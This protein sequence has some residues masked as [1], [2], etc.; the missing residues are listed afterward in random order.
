MIRRLI[1]LQVSKLRQRG[2][3]VG[4][5]S[6]AIIGGI[7]SYYIHQGL[8]DRDEE[9]RKKTLFNLDK[10]NVTTPMSGINGGYHGLTMPAVESEWVATKVEGKKLVE[11][12]K[13]WIIT[14]EAQWIPNSEIKSKKKQSK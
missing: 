13:V 1:R 10:F 7:A 5:L 12:H 6:G 9:V 2:A 4:A 8:N 11:G 14:E 3:L